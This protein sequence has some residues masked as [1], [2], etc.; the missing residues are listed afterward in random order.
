MGHLSF[1]NNLYQRL[2][3]EETPFR[4]MEEQDDQLAQLI[5]HRVGSVD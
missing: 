5:E 3:T 1:A 2:H 4:V